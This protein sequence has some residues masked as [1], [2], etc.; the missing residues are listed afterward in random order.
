MVCGIERKK[1]TAQI[2]R[3]KNRLLKGFKGD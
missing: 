1:G 3:V 2:D